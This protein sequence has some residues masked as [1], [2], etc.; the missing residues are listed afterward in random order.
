M[1]VKTTRDGQIVDLTDGFEKVGDRMRETAHSKVCFANETF[2]DDELTAPLL[3]RIKAGEHPGFTYYE[4][5]EPKDVGSPEPDPDSAAGLAQTQADAE[6]EPD[7]GG[8][9]VG[10]YDPSEH[11]QEDVIAHLKES[12][13]DEVAR[14]KAAEVAGHARKGITGYEPKAR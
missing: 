14:V 9:E 4:D 1:A 10:Q 8:A 6:P 11:N 5:D 2:A 3:E 7:A 12:D 13:P